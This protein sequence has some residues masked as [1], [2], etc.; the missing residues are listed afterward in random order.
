M[1]IK[2][3]GHA[4]F[5]LVAKDN[6]TIV[7]DPFCG[8][9]NCS[10]IVDADILTISHYHW[11]HSAVSRVT[12]NPILIDSAVDKTVKGIGIRGIVTNHDEK[13]GSLRGKSIVNVFKI[14]GIKIAHFGDIGQVLTDEFV[15]DLG[16]IDVMITPVGGLYT[17]DAFTAMEYV[18]AINPKIVIPMHY[19]YGDWFGQVNGVD[20]FVELC[21]NKSIEFLGDSLHI[22]KVG[23]P[24]STQYKIL[25]IL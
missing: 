21:N 22:D 7:C 23:L 3:L 8:E 9:G 12:N 6:T 5:M 2:W 10:Q 25:S 17:I 15:S 13:G 1:L 18:K 16:D 4:C 14:D 24:T 11:D 20:K 19:H